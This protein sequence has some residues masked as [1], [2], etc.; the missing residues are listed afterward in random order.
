MHP[1]YFTQQVAP[2]F[3]TQTTIDRQTS[4]L[5]KSDGHVL[6]ELHA[7]YSRV[8]R[9]RTRRPRET[10]AW[11]TAGRSG[12]LCRTRRKSPWGRRRWAHNLWRGR[13]RQQS[14]HSFKAECTGSLRTSKKWKRKER[15]M[16]R[17]NRTH[18]ERMWMTV[19]WRTQLGL[20]PSGAVCN[21]TMLWQ[22]KDYALTCSCW[23]ALC[24]SQSWWSCCHWCRSCNRATS[25][26]KHNQLLNSHFCSFSLAAIY[27]TLL[28]RENG[29]FE[30]LCLQDCGKRHPTL[31]SIFSSLVRDV[32]SLAGNLISSQSTGRCC[33]THLPRTTF[34]RAQLLHRFVFTCCQS[35]QSHIDLHAPAWL[36]SR[37]TLSACRPKTFTPHPRRAMSYTLQN[38]TPRTGTPSSL[39]PESVFQHSEQPCEDQRPQQSGALTEIPPLTWQDLEQNEKVFWSK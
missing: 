37:S 21:V 1:D 32:I 13:T 12:T 6:G 25:P 4:L 14:P 9:H 7:A 17:E 24:G 29:S 26:R 27:C 23:C 33:Q 18:H 39:F 16:S 15:S 3:R 8:R 31:N 36:K 2:F 28:H 11:R 19:K 34:S 22:T 20:E 5:V 10:L 30:V 35:V 38:L